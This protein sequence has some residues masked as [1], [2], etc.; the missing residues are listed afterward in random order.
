MIQLST[1]SLVLGAVVAAL[2]VFALIK[3]KEFT[4]AARAFP[5]SL[6]AGYVLM[7]ASAIVFL[8]FLKRET[9]ADF[10]RFKPT[11]MVIFAAATVG[12]CIFVKDFLAVRGL[13]LVLMILGK[14][15]V[16]VARPHLGESV[17]VLLIPT[18][19]YVLVIAGMW[20]TVSP[21][22]LRDLIAW[23]TASEGRLRALSLARLAFAVALIALG[24]LVY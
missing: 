24:L 9:L 18:W 10:E 11:L 21:W 2:Q 14:V 23:G 4:A 17:W 6:S 7:F 20:F 13:A 12:I 16:D 22:R 3:P 19:A 5:R 1:L 15:M 8:I